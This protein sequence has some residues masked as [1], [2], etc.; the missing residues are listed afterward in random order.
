SV[1]ATLFD[2]INNPFF[3]EREAIKLAFGDHGVVTPEQDTPH[4]TMATAQPLTLQPLVVP[5]TDLVGVNADRVFD[6]TAADVIGDLGVDA[7]NNSR[8]D[9]YAF[10]AQAGTLINLQVMSRVL[11][12]SQGS[13]DPTL[14]VYDSTGHVVACNDD[15][16]Q[17][18]DS[19]IID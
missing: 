7:S 2:A 14:T 6:V 13:F 1:H 3:G 9:F 5:D 4:Y 12:R 18:Q 10:A 8:T 15:S 16:F 11:D 17:N 19:T